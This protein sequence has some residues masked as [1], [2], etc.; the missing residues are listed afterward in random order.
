MESHSGRVD[1]TGGRICGA[2]EGV[3]GSRTRFIVTGHPECPVRGPREHNTFFQAQN[4]VLENRRKGS[5]TQNYT[6]PVTLDT[7]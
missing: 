3:R 7:G 4:L 5:P 6:S 2:Q 1:E